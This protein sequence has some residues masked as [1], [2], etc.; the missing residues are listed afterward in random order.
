MDR[1]RLDRLPYLSRKLD[2]L[3]P[4]LH[5]KQSSP[6]NIER[7]QRCVCVDAK[8]E[9]FVA[10]IGRKVVDSV[11]EALLVL[12]PNNFRSELVK[13]CIVATDR[14]MAEAGSCV[15]KAETRID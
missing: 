13:I 1:L 2:L 11:R 4:V 10:S 8:I 3:L 5:R 7:L 9:T 15:I 14:E 6:P 12:R